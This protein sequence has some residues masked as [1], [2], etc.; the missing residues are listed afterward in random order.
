[1]NKSM[2][3]LT[4]DLAAIGQSQY[5]DG[6]TILD[7]RPKEEY[8]SQGKIAGRSKNIDIFSMFNR[9]DFTLKSDAERKQAIKS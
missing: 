1:M 5:S 2:L 4:K 8:Q 9:E 3:M 7:G 6:L